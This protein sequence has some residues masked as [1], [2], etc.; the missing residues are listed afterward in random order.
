MTT[1]TVTD[2]LETARRVAAELEAQYPLET[3]IWGGIYCEY[4]R[5]L[6]AL[7]RTFKQPEP[8]TT[9]FETRKNYLP[10][11]MGNVKFIS[12]TSEELRIATIAYICLADARKKE[13]R[14]L[15]EVWIKAARE[16]V[17]DRSLNTVS[18]RTA[19]SAR[20]RTQHVRL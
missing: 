12:A 13:D 15:F 19:R 4:V 14:T 2:H 20:R 7:A 10:A 17:A 8:A 5:A 11:A 16:V 9:V 18:G 3:T 6:R 1:K